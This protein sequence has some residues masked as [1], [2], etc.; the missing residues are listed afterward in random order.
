MFAAPQPPPNAT[1]VRF[2]P[3]LEAH[4][5]AVAALENTAYSHPWSCGNF[6]DALKSGY[7]AQRLMA[8]DTLIGYFIAMQ[9]LDEVHLLNITVAPVYQ[10]QGWA[11]MMLEALRLWARGQAAQWLWLEVRAGN[12]RAMHVYERHGFR[13]VGL[14][15]GYYP[16]GHGQREDA[17][18]M[19]VKL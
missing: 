15:K 12:H 18:V 6:V 1:E 9:V 14:R 4:V 13:R 8:G 10:G 11:R 17:L 5:D 7:Q 2:E 3:L 19:S 16:N